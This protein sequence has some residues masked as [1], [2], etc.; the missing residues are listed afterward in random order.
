MS[1][2]WKFLPLA[3]FEHLQAAN[4]PDPA[5]PPSAFDICEAVNPLWDRLASKA[6]CNGISLGDGAR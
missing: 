1:E 6:Q 2:I 5:K 3:T 4:G